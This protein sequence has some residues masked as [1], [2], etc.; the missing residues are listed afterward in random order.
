MPNCYY[1]YMANNSTFCYLGNIGIASCIFP[2]KAK[3]HRLDTLAR[4]HLW[5]VGNFLV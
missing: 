3:G 5:N 1:G 4:Q 2:D